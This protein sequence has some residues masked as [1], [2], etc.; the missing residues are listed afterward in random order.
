MAW[1]NVAPNADPQDGV[2]VYIECADLDATNGARALSLSDETANNRV[3]IQNSS[4]NASVPVVT[5]GT[6]QANVN[7][8]AATSAD[9]I[10]LALAHN[11]L[12]ASLNGATVQTDASVTL[13]PMET[14]RCGQ[15]AQGGDYLG[16]TISRLTVFMT[17]KDDADLEVWAGQ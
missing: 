3:E 10:A 11:D 4:G 2:T 13:P 15:Q 1:D 9:R 5:N 14:L 7:A 8:G 17:R 6:S 12:A 16:S